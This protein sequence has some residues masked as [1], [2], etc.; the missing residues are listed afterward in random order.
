MKTASMA[1]LVFI[2]LGIVS[3]A[4]Q[5]I[6]YTTEKKVGTSV[7]STRRRTNNTTFHYH[8]FWVDCR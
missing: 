4:Y 3:L 6:T 1:G 8:R 2:V 5:G 7:Q